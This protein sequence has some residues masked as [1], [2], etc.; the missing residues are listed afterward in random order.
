MTHEALDALPR[1]QTVEY[2]RGLLVAHDIL[3]PRDRL[4]ATYE[5]W[6]RDKLEAIGDD[7]QRRIIERFGRWHHLRRLREHA[8]RAP[9]EP[10]P[11][12]SA[13]Q[14]TTLAI[15]F[16]AWLAT[17]RGHTLAECTQ[18][19]IDA[20]YARGPETRHNVARFLYWCRS[21]RLIPWLRIP[22]RDKVAH[23]LIGQQQRL[24]IIRL[25]TA[26]RRTRP[27]LP[28]GRMSGDAVRSVG[29]T[30]RHSHDRRRAR[31]GAGVRVRLTDEW[32]EVPEPVG[33]VFRHHL[34]NRANTQTAANATSRWLFPGIMP[35]QH[36]DT[37]SVLDTLRAAGIPVRATRNTTWQ[38]LVRAAPPQVLARALGISPMTAMQHAERAGSD[39]ARYA[40]DRSANRL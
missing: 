24:Q 33:A 32:I 40:A 18:A 3:V 26:A 36:L 37:K 16:V 7:E 34:D 19:D 23:D 39:W 14:S 5:L 29:R 22:H 8:S 13:K 25:G 38:Q 1:S 6:L 11:F 4:L 9:V 35:G 28:G 12:L 2:L 30:A 15:Q 31:R 27:G 20:W 17:A 21:Q 10:A